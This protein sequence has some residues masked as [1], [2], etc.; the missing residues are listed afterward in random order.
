MSKK[1]SWKC[2]NCNKS[3]M[4]SSLPMN[5]LE[6]GFFNSGKWYRYQ[7]CGYPCLIS[8]AQQRNKYYQMTGDSLG[9]TETV[10]K[11]AIK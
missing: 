8:W 6:I 11:E 7:C 10:E 4:S 9:Y 1:V 2:D 3:V 5:W